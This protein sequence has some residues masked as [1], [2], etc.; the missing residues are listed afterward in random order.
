MISLIYDDLA[1]IS[2]QELFERCKELDKAIDNWNPS[3]AEDLDEFWNV[4]A[5]M[6]GDFND[7]YVL[8]FRRMF[9][10]HK[11]FYRVNPEW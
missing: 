8:L 11:F 2:K 1:K 10:A 4:R 3:D 5:L 9:R 6:V 7:H